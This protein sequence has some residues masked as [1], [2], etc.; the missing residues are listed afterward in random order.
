MPVAV[1]SRFD[2]DRSMKEPP[3]FASVAGAIAD[4]T[5]ARML[6]TLMSGRALTATELALEGGVTPSTASSHL[7]CL[8]T[9]GIVSIAK[10]GRH[11]YFRISALE[12][13]AVLEQLMNLE[14]SGG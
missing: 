1:A 9:R 5:R 4:V 7:A 12:V 13:A 6:A 10:Q 3:N 8:T 14:V 2:Y 11:R